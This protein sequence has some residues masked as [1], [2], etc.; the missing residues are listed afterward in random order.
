MSAAKHTN[1]MI[2]ESTCGFG[3]EEGD[4][5]RGEFCG[6]DKAGPSGAGEGDGVDSAS[7]RALNNR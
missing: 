1:S 7:L 5:A 2:E 6:T 4:T 3:A